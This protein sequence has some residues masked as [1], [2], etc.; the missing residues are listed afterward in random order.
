MTGHPVRLTASSLS[1]LGR[2]L[3]D[4]PRVRVVQDPE[5]TLREPCLHVWGHAAMWRSVPGTGGPQASR[6]SHLQLV[7][8]LPVFRPSIRMQAASTTGRP[9]LIQRVRDLHTQSPFLAWPKLRA[10]GQ[11]PSANASAPGGTTCPPPKTTPPAGHL[12]GRLGGDNF[13]TSGHRALTN[14]TFEMF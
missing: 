3:L 1:R 6:Y 5:R 8:G 14:K 11:M 13:G 4:C 10:R 12:T 2:G 7:G 9:T